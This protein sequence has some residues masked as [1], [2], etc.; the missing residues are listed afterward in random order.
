VDA[1][2]ERCTTDPPDLILLDLT[3]ADEDGLE[4]L[5]RLGAAGRTAP[6]TVA[7]TGHDDPTTRARCLAAGCLDVLLKPV[8]ARELLRRVDEW[9]GARHEV[10]GTR[11]EG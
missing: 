4:L 6:R 5:T 8:P 2:V 10:R 7:M 1:G 11:H 3:L 9:I